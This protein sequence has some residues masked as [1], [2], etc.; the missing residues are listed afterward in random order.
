VSTYIIPV[1]VKTHA[2]VIGV[3]ESTGNLETTPGV[4]VFDPTAADSCL[5]GHHNVA[6]NLFQNSPIF[7]AA[8]FDFGGTIVGTTQYNDALQ[9]GSFWQVLGSDG[10]DYHVLLNPVKA[11]ASIVIDVPAAHGLAIPAYFAGA[12]ACGAIGVVDINWLD[13]YLQSTVLPALLPHGVKPATFPIFLYHNVVQS[14]GA[15]AAAS[16]SCCIL[17]YHSTAGFPIQT[18]AV[19]D[20]E[21]TGFYSA[22]YQDTVAVSHEVAEWM[23][24]PFGNNAAPAWGGTGQDLGVCQNNLE[25]ADPLSGTEAPP[26]VMGNGFTYHLQ[27][28]AFP[29]WFFGGPSTGING[30][31]SSNGTFLTDAG[32][33]CQASSSSS[34]GGLSGDVTSNSSG[35]TPSAWKLRELAK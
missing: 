24:D 2:I 18:Y 34:G 12:S 26:I 25:V 15:P 27:E 29:S 10:G 20:F 3:D 30:W 31:Y 14:D 17:G 32:P 9:R 4:S 6:S 7:K 16:S 1:I 22:A 21:T 33:V 28:V 11:L 19:A 23:N 5:A 8:T 35:K 13:S